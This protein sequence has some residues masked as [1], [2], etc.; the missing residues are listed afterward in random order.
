MAG[1]A[2][3]RGGSTADEAEGAADD[4]AEGDSKSDAATSGCAPCIADD[5]VGRHVHSMSMTCSVGSLAIA[6]AHS[7]I[8]ATVYDHRLLHNRALL[9]RLTNTQCRASR[10]GRTNAESR[11]CERRGR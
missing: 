2:E 7:T 9:V 11:Q 10:D 1:C 4:K 6:V 8:S 5:V 3:V